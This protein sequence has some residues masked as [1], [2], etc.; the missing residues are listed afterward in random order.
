MPSGA[1]DQCGRAGARSPDAR[2]LRGATV[3]PRLLLFHFLPC[4][5]P[6]RDTPGCWVLRL[7]RSGSGTAP[8][9]R[10]RVLGLRRRPL[11]AP[12]A[13]P[14][15]RQRRNGRA[16]G[17]PA[18]S[19][20]LPLPGARWVVLGA[21]G[22]LHRVVQSL[23]PQ[24]HRPACLPRA[25]CRSPTACRRSPAAACRRSPTLVRPSLLPQEHARTNRVYVAQNDPAAALGYI[26][27]GGM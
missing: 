18:Q 2:L 12:Q 7:A 17:L 8:S 9:Q 26:Q 4:L 25:C 20:Q 11:P 15:A 27:L 5:A 14:G 6:D 1:G 19:D 22:P 24:S 21:P 3:A 10:A 13:A 23:A 16:H